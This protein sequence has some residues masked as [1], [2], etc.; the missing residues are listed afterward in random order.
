LPI[1]PVV[2]FLRVALN[3]VGTLEHMVHFG[4]LETLRVQLL[5]L[6]LPAI[7]ALE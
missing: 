3:G 4:S 6:A 2:L 5:Y 1:L 7:N